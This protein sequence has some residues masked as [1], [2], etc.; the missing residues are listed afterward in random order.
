MTNDSSCSLF[1]H[2]LK[3]FKVLFFKMLF[4]ICRKVEELLESIGPIGLILFSQTDDS[5]CFLLFLRLKLFKVLFFKIFFFICE[6][7]EELLEPTGPIGLTHFSQEIIV[8]FDVALLI[9]TQF[10]NH[11]LTP[12]DF[13]NYFKQFLQE[14]LFRV[15]PRG[16][17]FLRLQ[18]SSCLWLSSLLKSMFR[19]VNGPDPRAYKRI[20]PFLIFS[21]FFSG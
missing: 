18:G 19:Y 10:L 11:F 14:Y 21:R 8:A 3:F 1:F 20:Q 7:V 12:I 9:G 17:S 4:S 2:F 13:P 16:L 6:K 15:P 5:S